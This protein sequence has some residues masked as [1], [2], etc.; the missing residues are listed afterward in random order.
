MQKQPSIWRSG[1]RDYEHII[2]VQTA[3]DIFNCK[4]DRID[5]RCLNTDY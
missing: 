5:D 2:A 1:V 3:E 4:M